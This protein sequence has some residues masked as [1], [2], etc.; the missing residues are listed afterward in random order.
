MKGIRPIRLVCDGLKSVQ[1]PPLTRPRIAPS[2]ART[3]ELVQWATVLYAYS[4][5]AHIH[6]ILSGLIVLADSENTPAAYIV[7]RHIFEWTAQAC[8]VSGKL[9]DCYDAKDWNEAWTVLTPASIGNMWAK[10]HGA[11]Y[12]SPSQQPVPESP[13]SVRIG[14]AISAYESYRLQKYGQDDVKDTYG[15]LSEFSHPNSA[16]LQQY[17]VIGTDGTM[18]VKYVEDYDASPLPFI[19][20]CLI[21]LILFVDGLLQLAM[22]TTVRESIRR[23]LDELEK[24]APR[25]Q[26]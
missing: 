24:L 11:K 22:D 8:Y 4:I 15:L 25:V 21:D 26:T 19:N 20:W 6:K 7:C 10:K 13:D 9:K 23:V 14:I 1:L 18:V 17:H 2:E 16:C 5:I 3:E 12:A